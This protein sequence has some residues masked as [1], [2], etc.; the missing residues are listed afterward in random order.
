VSR[1]RKPPSQPLQGPVEP[2][3]KWRFEPWRITV[4]HLF[5]SHSVFIFAKRWKLQWTLVKLHHSLSQCS[6]VLRW[7]WTCLRR[8][9]TDGYWSEGES[10]PVWAAAVLFPAF[11]FGD[12]GGRCWNLVRVYR[13]RTVCCDQRR[14]FKAPLQT[15]VHVEQVAYQK[16]SVL[17]GISHS[18]Q[19]CLFLRNRGILGPMDV[20]KQD[21]PIWN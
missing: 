11:K 13:L 1:W 6:K 16:R 12:F 14:P 7:I 3:Q 17:G 19:R 21:S 20:C 9:A 18:G 4:S 2:C 5:Y 8:G 15:W 10:S